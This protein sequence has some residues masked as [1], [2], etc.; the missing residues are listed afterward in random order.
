M[1]IGGMDNKGNYKTD[2]HLK[3]RGDI[4]SFLDN[5]HS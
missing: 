1:L 3:A 4:N 5:L 2:S